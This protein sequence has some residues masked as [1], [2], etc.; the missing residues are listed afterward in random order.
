MDDL[1]EPY[2]DQGLEAW[3]ILLANSNF[4]PPD[5]AYCKQYKAQHNL[6]MRVLY[7]GNAVTSIYGGKETSVITNEEGTIVFKAVSDT[8][9]SI[10]AAMLAEL[11]TGPGQCNND[12]I[13]QG[14]GTCLPTPKS[15]GYVCSQMCTP[16]EEGT[17]PEGETCFTPASGLY[18]ACYDDAMIP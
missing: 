7:D 4:E 3:V 6:K 18:S 17:C 8:P 16:G 2:L 5:A 12:E 9:E 13:C 1:F 15:D 11:E 14:L 10:L